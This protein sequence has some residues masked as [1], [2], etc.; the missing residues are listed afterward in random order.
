MYTTRVYMNLLKVSSSKL[1]RIG[2]YIFNPHFHLWGEVARSM[3][4][5]QLTP[6]GKAGASAGEIIPRSRN[7]RLPGDRN[8]RIVYIIWIC[9]ESFISFTSS[10]L[11][12]YIVVFISSF[13][14]GHPYLARLMQKVE[15]KYLRR[16]QAAQHRSP[17]V[18]WQASSWLVTNGSRSSPLGFN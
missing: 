2:R 11:F 10:S 13:P 5:A 3:K 8:I 12:S 14:N 4:N 7:M 16:F 1:L 6:L 18:H 9:L 17:L 15:L